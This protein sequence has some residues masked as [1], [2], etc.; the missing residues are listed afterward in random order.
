MLLNLIGCTCGMSSGS[1]LLHPC[2]QGIAFGD[3]QWIWS[4][5]SADYER[6]IQGLPRG[7]GPCG[8]GERR[9]PNAD[10]DCDGDKKYSDKHSGPTCHTWYIDH[11]NIL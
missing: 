4:I 10:G 8:L 3:V 6:K 7:G 1:L 2:K 9:R 5:L 11:S